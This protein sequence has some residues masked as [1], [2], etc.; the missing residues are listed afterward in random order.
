VRERDEAREGTRM[1]LILEV[2][3][4]RQRVTLAC[5]GKLAGGAE[6]QAF[7]RSALLLMSG[8]DRITIDVAGLRGADGGGI[9][10]LASVLAQ[11]EEQGKRVRILHPGAWLLP[12]L[13]SQGMSRFL[14][15]FAPAATA[16]GGASPLYA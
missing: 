4:G 13:Q 3:T 9:A 16:V 11:A 14:E 1:D 12:L 5:H 10:T 8:F 15:P 7:R 6:A 2:C